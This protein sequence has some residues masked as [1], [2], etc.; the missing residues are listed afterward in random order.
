MIDNINKNLLI[1]LCFFSAIFHNNYS[2]SNNSKDLKDLKDCYKNSPY[3]SFK[4]TNY[5]EIYN[6]MFSKFRGKACT[7][8][9]VGVL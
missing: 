8:I 5:L 1:I 9:K 2:Y 7:F 4:V 6:N 3:H